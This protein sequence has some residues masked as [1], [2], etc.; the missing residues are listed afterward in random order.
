ME[1]VSILG[2]P[3]NLRIKTCQLWHKMPHIEA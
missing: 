3:Q 2:D 1:A